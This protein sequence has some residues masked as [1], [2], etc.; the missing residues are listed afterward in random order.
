MLAERTWPSLSSPIT[1][2]AQPAPY[3]SLGR[4]RRSLSDDLFRVRPSIYWLDFG[5][6][7]AI[8]SVAF[9]LTLPHLTP[10]LPFRFLWLVICVLGFYRSL[11]FVHGLAILRG[12]GRRPSRGVGKALGASMFFLP[13]LPYTN[14]IFH[15]L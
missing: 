11:L 7:M 8:S 4:V 10:S 6:S 12:A 13:G 9:C 2:Q 15:H 1:L 3:D 5:A 14:H